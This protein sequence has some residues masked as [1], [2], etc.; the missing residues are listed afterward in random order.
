MARDFFSDAAALISWPFFSVCWQVVGFC[1]LRTKYAQRRV[2]LLQES[3]RSGSSAPDDRPSAVEE[4]HDLAARVGSAWPRWPTLPLLC[5][6]VVTL[7]FAI[8]CGAWLPL[9][10]WLQTRY[11]GNPDSFAS[12]LLH[13]HGLSLACA[14]VAVSVLTMLVIAGH[15]TLMLGMLRRIAAKPGVV[16]THATAITASV[17]AVLA[18]V[19]AVTLVLQGMVGYSVGG[20]QWLFQNRPVVTTLGIAVST[21]PSLLCIGGSVVDLLVTVASRGVAGRPLQLALADMRARIDRALLYCWFAA[22]QLV[23]IVCAIVWATLNVNGS[24]E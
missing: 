24:P 16:T 23:A 8:V 9:A 14:L 1:L 22:G 19:I 17:L 6:I 3:A 11:I 21:F 15:V 12:P 18:T 20:V 13:L 10:I 2:R 7:G 5:R 4:L